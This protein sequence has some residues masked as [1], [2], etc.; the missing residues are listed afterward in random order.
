MWLGLAGFGWDLYFIVSGTRSLALGLKSPISASVA[1][2]SEDVESPSV[3][4]MVP[5]SRTPAS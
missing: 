2:C 3:R 1:A 5:A 4:S